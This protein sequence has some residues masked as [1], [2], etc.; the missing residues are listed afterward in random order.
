MA[1]ALGGTLTFASVNTESKVVCSNS[2]LGVCSTVD[3]RFVLAVGTGKSSI[4]CISLITLARKALSCVDCEALSA[5]QTNVASV[6]AQLNLLLA[7]E[8]KEAM[9]A[10]AVLELS[11][12]LLLALTMSNGVEEGVVLDTLLADTIVLASQVAG[13]TSVRRKVVFTNGTTKARRAGTVRGTRLAGTSVDTKVLSFN[14]GILFAEAGSL[15]LAVLAGIAGGVGVGSI[16]VAVVDLA[17]VAFGS[18]ALWGRE[19]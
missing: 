14:L 2:R 17:V 4:S 19:G 18:D 5:I 16:A 12:E 7:L 3:T 8:A 11:V 15:V 10:D 13:N 6:T 1:L 9:T